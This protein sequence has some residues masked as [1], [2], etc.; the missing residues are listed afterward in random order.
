VANA[1]RQKA[2]KMTN[3]ILH[4]IYSLQYMAG[5]CLTG[6]V[7]TGR[8]ALPVIIVNRITG[9]LTMPIEYVCAFTIPFINS[10]SPNCVLCKFSSIC[11]PGIMIIWYGF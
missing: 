8:K 11:I 5:H 2:M 1:N 6:C 10:V 4:G 9:M 3:D 7:E